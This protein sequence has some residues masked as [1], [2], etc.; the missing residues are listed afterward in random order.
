MK[1]EY[2]APVSKC[3]ILDGEFVCQLT[4][5]SK[6]YSEDIE[7]LSKERQSVDFSNEES[8]W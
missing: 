7:Q 3:A 6:D 2:K 8:I 4:A 5:V 1:K